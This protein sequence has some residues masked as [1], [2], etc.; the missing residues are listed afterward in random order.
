[1]KT[2]KYRFINIILFVVV[3]GMIA[4]SFL[5]NFCFFNWKFVLKGS[6][7]EVAFLIGVPVI[8]V[9]AGLQFAKEDFEN[10]ITGILLCAI[11]FFACLG[12]IPNIFN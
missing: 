6:P 11:L 9:L 1:M 12:G 2:S 8:V 5:D 3:V 7:F 10:K 4:Y